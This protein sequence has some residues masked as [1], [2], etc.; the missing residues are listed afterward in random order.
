[1]VSHGRNVL[2]MGRNS[3]KLEQLATELSQ[4]FA[5]VDFSNS[6][7]LEDAL[8]QAAGSHGG[9]EGIVN[10]VGSV[11]LKPAHATIQPARSPVRRNNRDELA[12]C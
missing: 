6:Q 7:P 3:E 5:M 12:I 9:L 4:P 2:L 8:L 1:M 10:C 11:F